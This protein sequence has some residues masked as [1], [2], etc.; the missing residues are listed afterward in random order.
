MRLWYALGNDVQETKHVRVVAGAR[1][2]LAGLLGKENLKSLLRRCSVKN[3]VCIDD[4]PDE[5]KCMDALYIE[6]FLCVMHPI[7]ANNVI[8]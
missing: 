3:T 6:D 8:G 2:G 7:L 5:L 1:E 4:L